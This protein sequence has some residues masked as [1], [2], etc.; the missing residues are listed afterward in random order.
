MVIEAESFAII[1]FIEHK[2]GKKGG[3]CMAT[4]TIAIQ[5]M[6]CSGCVQSVTKALHAIAGVQNVDVSLE[7]HQATV[8]F[9]DTQ[10]TVE[11]LKEAIEDAGYD[12]A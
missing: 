4:T 1:P 7:Q 3:D 2:E 11:Q 10:V 6:T 5:G 9:D 12:V 8:T